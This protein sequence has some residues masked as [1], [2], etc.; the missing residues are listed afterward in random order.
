ML[1]IDQNSKLGLKGELGKDS[2]VWYCLNCGAVW[3][4]GSSKDNTMPA[5]CPECKDK[6]KSYR[7]W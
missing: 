2:N 1:P 3:E 6:K 4:G 7:S 5:I